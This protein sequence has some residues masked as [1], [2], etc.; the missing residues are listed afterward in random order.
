MN[1]NVTIV[2]ELNLSQETYKHL[3]NIVNLH[4][5]LKTECERLIYKFVVDDLK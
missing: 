5:L 4:D 3:N 2:I 1:E